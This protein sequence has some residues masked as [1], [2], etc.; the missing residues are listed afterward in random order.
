MRHLA[1]FVRGV[2][3][4]LCTV[5]RVPGFC[6][7]QPL[8][9]GHL[10]DGHQY[11]FVTAFLHLLIFSPFTSPSFFLPTTTMLTSITSSLRPSFSL[12]TRALATTNVVRQQPNYSEVWSTIVR[13]FYLFVRRFRMVESKCSGLP[14]CRAREWTT[15]GPV[16]SSPQSRLGRTS[17][18]WTETSF[19]CAAGHV[20]GVSEE[21]HAGHP[22]SPAGAL[23]QAIIW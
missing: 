16:P 20:Q 6:R 5:P 11:T 4:V 9:C 8:P 14:M 2:H 19:F 10:V 1:C 3:S 18:T 13:A 21:V 22:C 15:S 17:T 12:A 7:R 23:I